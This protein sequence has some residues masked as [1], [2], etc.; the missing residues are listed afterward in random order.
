MPTPRATN[1]IV[2][3]T[4]PPNQSGSPNVTFNKDNFEAVIFQKGHNVIHEHAL[5]CPCK[6]EK[7]DNLSSCRNCGGGGWIFIN[8]NKTKMILSSMNYGTQFKEW[9][10]E[11]LGRVNITARDIDVLSYM[12]RITSLDGEVMFSEVIHAKDF[13]E[14]LCA[15]TIYDIK[16]VVQAFVFKEDK[17]PLQR[18]VENTDF[19]I[20]G[21]VV[22]LERSIFNNYTQPIS[23]TITYIH[24]PQF[25]VMDLMRDVRLSYTKAQKAFQLPISGMG[26]RSHYI[27]DRQNFG[28]DYL[29]DNSF[30]KVPC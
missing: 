24:A 21:N 27:L 8:P 30:N 16:R 3:E 13:H 6:S 29:F 7:M 26:R 1:S 9:S 20:A 19:T 14:L 23:V 28:H 5:P 17:Q 2:T 18:I 15:F 11:N 4:Q 25:H 10:Q 12:D 22:K